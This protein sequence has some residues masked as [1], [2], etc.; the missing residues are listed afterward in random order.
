MIN[1]NGNR[2]ENGQS[3]WYANEKEEQV[4]SRTVGKNDAD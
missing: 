4:W 2:S 3:E 1:Q